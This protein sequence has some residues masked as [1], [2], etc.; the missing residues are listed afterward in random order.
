MGDPG[1]RAINR[2]RGPH[3]TQS[4]YHS[5]W[6]RVAE[7]ESRIATVIFSFKTVTVCF[8]SAPPT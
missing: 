3:G 7:Q 1:F 6:L 2:S 8:T 4:S 5:N